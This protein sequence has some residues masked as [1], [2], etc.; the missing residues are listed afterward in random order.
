MLYLLGKKSLNAFFSYYTCVLALA[1]TMFYPLH[2]RGIYNSILINDFGLGTVFYLRV[3]N[4]FPKMI[5]TLFLKDLNKNK[6][7]LIHF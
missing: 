6:Y 7:V 3:I 4:I 2:Q 1:P 5:E